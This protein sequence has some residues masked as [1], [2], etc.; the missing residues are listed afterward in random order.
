MCFGPYRSTPTR[1]SAWRQK[2]PSS[3]PGEVSG[4]MSFITTNGT[5][6]SRKAFATSTEL[7]SR[8]RTSS[9]APSGGSWPIKRTARSAVSTGL[10]TVNPWSAMVC[11]RPCAVRKSS[12]TI[13]T[14]LLRK[15]T[16]DLQR[17]VRAYPFAHHPRL[18]RRSVSSYSRPCTRRREADQSSPDRRVG[19]GGWRRATP[20]KIARHG[21]AVPVGR[22]GAHTRRV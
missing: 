2:A 15:S 7:P 10:T 5:P 12:S 17:T 8:R 22:A 6:R 13:R 3:T 11:E 1:S 18:E 21:D 19:F 4:K 14:F 20:R 9:R 16:P